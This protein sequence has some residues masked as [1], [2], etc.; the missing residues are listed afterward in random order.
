MSTFYLTVTVTALCGIW[1]V[2]EFG[3]KSLFLDA[4][5]SRLFEL[6]AELFAMAKEG[7]LSFDDEAYRVIELVL[8]GS[9][10]FAHR[11]SFLSYIMSSLENHRAKRD[12]RDYV[13]FSQQIALKVSRL[14]PAAQTELL[15][16][17]V[18]LRSALAL[19]LVATSLIFKVAMCIYLVVKLFRP[20]Q[21][22]SKVTQQVYVIQREAYLSAKTGNVS[23]A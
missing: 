9:I 20:K 6:R 18:K 19:Y 7:K 15:S 2:W 16:I 5:R 3:F 10:R 1:I 14:S 17:L 21:A 11:L 22:E 4:F 13:D 23:A 8:N 12:D